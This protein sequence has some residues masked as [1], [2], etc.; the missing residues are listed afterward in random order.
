M[1]PKLSGG[2][3]R[4]KTPSALVIFDSKV[5]ELLGLAVTAVANLIV[6]FSVKY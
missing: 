1:Q 6:G 5:Q 2:K 3:W 4:G